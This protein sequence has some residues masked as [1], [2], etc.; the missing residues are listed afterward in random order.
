MADKINQSQI[1]N[2]EIDFSEFNNKITQ[3]D[4]FFIEDN[5]KLQSYDHNQF[6]SYLN[7]LREYLKQRKIMRKQDILN[8]NRYN[9]KN[10]KKL[11]NISKKPK[12]WKVFQKSFWNIAKEKRENDHVR[13]FGESL[14]SCHEKLKKQQAQDKIRDGKNE[15]PSIPLINPEGIFISIYCYL[16]LFSI[17]YTLIVTPIAFSFEF[18]S[19]S[20][21]RIVNNIIEVLIAILYFIDFFVTVRTPIMTK[22]LMGYETRGLELI[23]IYFHS[24]LLWD[25]LAFLPQ[26]FL[27][28]KEVWLFQRYFKLLKL[29]WIKN[30]L[31]I[32]IQL[33]NIKTVGGPIKV[34]INTFKISNFCRVF[35]EQIVQTFLVIHTSACFWCYLA[36]ENPDFTDTWLILTDLDTIDTSRAYLLGCYWSISTISTVGFG[37]I[38]ATNTQE[39]ILSQ[40]LISF[41]VVFYSKSIGIQSSAQVSESA[42]RLASKLNVIEQ[43]RMNSDS[44]FD[45]PK[46]LNSIRTNFTQ[47]LKLNEGYNEISCNLAPIYNSIMSKSMI[48]DMKDSNLFFKNKNI[49][50]IS[51]IV[52]FQDPLTVEKGDY[53]YLTHDLPQLVYIIKDGR[54]NF[55]QNRGIVFKSYVKGTYLGEIEAFKN[56]NRQFAVKAQNKTELLTINSETFV[57]ILETFPEYHRQFQELAIER[58]VQNKLS[59]RESDKFKYIQK[60]DEFWSKDQEVQYPKMTRKLQQSFKIGKDK[61]KIDEFSLRN[62]AV[63]NPIDSNHQKNSHQ[64]L[65]EKNT[66]NNNMNLTESQHSFQTKN[67]QI[68]EFHGNSDVKQDFS[69]KRILK[70][71]HLVHKYI[72]E[73]NSEKYNIDYKKDSS[74]NKKHKNEYEVPQQFNKADGVVNSVGNLN[75]NYDTQKNTTDPKNSKKSQD[76]M[77]PLNEY[78]NSL[79]VMVENLS[80]NLKDL[81]NYRESQ[82]SFNGIIS[83]LLALGRSYVIKE[84]ENSENQEELNPQVQK[85]FD[86]VLEILDP[87]LLE[88]NSSVR[89]VTNSKNL[90]ENLD[91]KIENTRENLNFAFQIKAN[92]LNS[93]EKTETLQPNIQKNTSSNSQKHVYYNQNLLLIENQSENHFEEIQNSS[94][95]S[96]ST[97]SLSV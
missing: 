9:L 41:G 87:N 97:N 18:S 3:K 34:M 52:P 67:P 74:S 23:D 72:K 21:F 82:N 20:V 60:S 75:L 5:N 78:L 90:S 63:S 73:K 15:N 96:N 19:D 24:Y 14:T 29:N 83:H 50:F 35:I 68:T 6:L 59:I 79:T 76:P 80:T 57:K 55:I 84:I 17:S 2:I 61:L 7:Y 40:I 54:V 44:N 69:P 53:I 22:K 39:K 11:D 70:N 81:T 47:N 10:E 28:G 13:S 89:T 64:N 88:V 49:D 56:I 32:D 1:N 30:Y 46:F 31:Y 42:I 71:S 12:F 95:I 45:A 33:D 8:R 85:M 4:N 86:S 36:L 91:E 58:D 77:D 26:K 38:R 93:P 43:I 51:S 65:D 27:V 66:Q 48:G 16:V 94:S 25:F 62:I 37:D 92:L